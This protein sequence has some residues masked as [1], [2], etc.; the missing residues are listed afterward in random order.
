[1]A[2]ADALAPLAAYERLSHAHAAVMERYTAPSPSGSR[3]AAPGGSTSPGAVPQ[4]HPSP[5]LP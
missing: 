1:M 2:R 3:G 5:A 4:P